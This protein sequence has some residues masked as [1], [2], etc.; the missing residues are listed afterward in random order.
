VL[1]NRFRQLR[2]GR[3]ILTLGAG[4]LTVASLLLA[5][6]SGAATSAE[7]LP[8]LALA[9]FGIGVV[10]VPLTAIVLANLDVRHAGAASGVLS[11]A[12][13]VGGALGIA[14]LGVVFFG[15]LPAGGFAHAF[16]VSLLALGVPAVATAALAGLLSRS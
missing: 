15:A 4:F 12:L 5:V 8:G 14:V 11:T 9:G 16:T 3:H 2:L 6:S 7:L 13:Q 1:R 10:L